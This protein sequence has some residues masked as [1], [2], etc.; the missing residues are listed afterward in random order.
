MSSEQS[1]LLSDLDAYAIA[2]A[3]AG[4]DWSKVPVSALT[5][6]LLTRL[7]LKKPHDWDTLQRIL[8]PDLIGQIFAINPLAELPKPKAD[9]LETVPSLPS[10]QLNADQEREGQTVGRWL[11]DYVTWAGRVANET[12]L[13]FLWGAGLFLAAVAIA[14]RLYVHAPWGQQIFPNLYVMLIAV[15]TYYRKSASLNLASGVIRV[16]MPHMLLPQPGSPENFMNMLGGVL[17]SNI[18]TI[19]AID[20]ERLKDGNEFAAQRALVRDEISAVFK[21]MGRDYMAG[22][23]EII[24]QLYDCPPYLDSNTNNRGLVVIRNAALSIL[25]A[26]TPAELSTAVNVNDWY[27]GN[28]ARFGLLT[29]EPDYKERPAQ[30][31]SVPPG[32]L[33]TRLRTLHEKLPAPRT[34]ESQ[35]EAWSLTAHVWD[36]CHAYE[37]ALRQMTAPDSPLDDRLRAVY[38]RLHVQA[39]KVAII[40][41]A[42]DWADSQ[43]NGKPI[44]QPAHWYRAQQITEQWRAS[45][46]RLL[47]DLSESTESRLETRILRLLKAHPGELTL[48]DIYKELHADRKP[49]A[50]IL[51][52]LEQDGQVERIASS[53]RPGPHT[54]RYR[55][56]EC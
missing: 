29:P 12:P 10:A 30:V 23:K 20:R 32:N 19:P 38:G 36:Y 47:Q 48:R 18:D 46:H 54:E 5:S 16:A 3:L 41:A 44:V 28:L 1:S 26:T 45:A 53:M 9:D 13:I 52:S 43:D 49:V 11:G 33:V 4:L 56:I 55:L 42:L 37:Q 15:S 31:E 8:N 6:A 35:P 22:M 40:F 34:T 2:R 51:Q 24:M 21:A 39:L 17:P 25:G 14:R 27:N 50:D 7:D